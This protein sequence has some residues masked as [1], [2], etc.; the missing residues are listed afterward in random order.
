MAESRPSFDLAALFEAAASAVA[1]HQREINALDGYNGNH[2][3]NMVRN[4]Q[5]ITSTLRAH[6]Q[7]PPSEALN[8]AGRRLQ[9]N[10]AGG[11]SQFYAQG[12]QKAAERLSGKSQLSAADGMTLIETLLESI[13]AE[14]YPKPQESAPTVLDLL[15]GL[16]GGTPQP[17][18]EP[19]PAQPNQLGGLLTALM[20]GGA[21]AGPAQPAPAQQTPDP[22]AALFGMLTG[23]GVP[24]APQAAPVDD[25]IDLG[26]VME[27]LL[28]ASLAYI[29]ARQT[30]ADGGQAA[31]AA[32]TQALL[33]GQR[34]QARTSRQ[35]AGTVIARSMLKALLN[36]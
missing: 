23:A 4:V 14:G 8:L 2:G 9:E 24:Q 34:T 19:V 3:D 21:Q 28:P 6:D 32:L 33:G 22:L 1:A 30:G 16:T 18:P 36:R 17:A 15:T 35:A 5:T 11:T 13:P 12:L 10:G 20:G 26:D 7:A 25:G 29:Q 31:Q 27:K